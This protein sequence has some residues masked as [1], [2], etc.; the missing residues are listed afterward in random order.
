M[1]SKNDMKMVKNPTKIKF[2]LGFCITPHYNPW[3]CRGGGWAIDMIEKLINPTST[4]LMLLG[5]KRTTDSV[6]GFLFLKVKTKK[7]N[8]T[9]ILH[10]QNKDLDPRSWSRMSYKYKVRR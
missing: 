1:S 10:T 9:K 6:R 4:K 2:L 8:K 5:Q 3:L 7:E